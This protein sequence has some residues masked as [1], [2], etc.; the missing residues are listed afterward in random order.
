MEEVS[1][2]DELER[3]GRGALLGF[4]FDILDII[5]GQK[6]RIKQELREELKY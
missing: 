6:D 3:A 2:G 5:F 1:L 4:V